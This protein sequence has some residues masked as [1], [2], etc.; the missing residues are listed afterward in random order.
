MTT[1]PPPS[2][3][4]APRGARAARGTRAVDDQV[5][6]G[7]AL[8][9]PAVLV[10]LG[11]L[12][13]AA[14]VVD[15]DEDARGD[16]VDVRENRAR[17]VWPAW[18][19]DAVRGGRFTRAI[20]DWVADHF[21]GRDALLDVAAVAK[22][23]RGFG[24]ADERY[25]AQALGDFGL[26]DAAPRAHT[27]DAGVIK[28][29]ADDAGPALPVVDAGVTGA[30]VDAGA[31]TTQRT[32]A[33]GVGVVDTRALLYFGGDD[34]T[35]RAFA[36]A[37]NAWAAALPTT[38]TLDLLVTP[39]ATHY[40]L[41]DDQRDRSLPER[42]NLAALRRALSP[43]V[44]FVDVEAALSPHVD[45]QIFFRTDHHW[46][47]LGAFYAY[48]AWATQAG[49]VPVTRESLER[50]ARPPT[51]GSLY[52]ATQSQA[53]ARHPEPTEYWLP[54]AAYRAQRW[55]SLTEPPDV[56]RFLFERERGYAVFLG[57]DDPLLVATT[58]HRTGRRALLVKNSYG[59]ALAPWLLHH[60]DVVVVVD[61]RYFAGSARAL[62]DKHRI[63]DVLVVNATVTANSRPHARRLK[64]VLHGRGAAWE[65]A[66]PGSA[67]P[68]TTTAPLTTTTAADSVVDAGTATLAP[69]APSA[70]P[71]PEDA[72]KA[73]GGRAEDARKTR[74]GRAEDAL[75][76]R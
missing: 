34:D 74:G 41:P 7:A 67:P 22:G 44:R 65:P 35:A 64:E 6:L 54:S 3:P 8:A 75:R 25:P 63:T 21:P 37:V 40:Y 70:S 58:E 30:V 20:D 55:R 27:V 72:L 10:L 38:V 1:S 18:S 51:L 14:R 49:L 47:G 26:S 56:A 12:F 42:E 28:G 50:R 11:M 23:A 66:R 9:V 24:V 46:T 5:P 19:W 68:T 53:L 39:T 45:E 36:D 16:D 60:F 69:P 48:A 32:Y 57:G 59:N 52:R 31:P 76:T 2:S 33:G 73:R 62:V 43:R 71:A 13:V 29:G 15:L 17:A 61:Y 4:A